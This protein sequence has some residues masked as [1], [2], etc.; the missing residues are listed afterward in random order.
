MVT[1][2][3]NLQGTIRSHDLYRGRIDYGW[4]RIMLEAIVFTLLAII[5]SYY[6]LHFLSTL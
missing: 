1:T 3:K 2:Y 6:G 5:I 4:E